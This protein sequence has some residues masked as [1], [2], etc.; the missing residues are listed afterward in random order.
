[1]RSDETVWTLKNQISLGLGLS[2]PEFVSQDLTPN[3]RVAF[4]AMVNV[5][6]LEARQ[7]KQFSKIYTSKH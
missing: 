7:M 5:V 6:H 1:M 2:I 3:A 4:K